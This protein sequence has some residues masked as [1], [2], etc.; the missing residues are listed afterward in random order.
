MRV[1]CEGQS[2]QCRCWPCEYSFK[3]WG[4]L[5][6]KTVSAQDYKFMTSG[7]GPVYDQLKIHEN[8]RKEMVWKIS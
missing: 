4:Y 3:V 1:R 6:D 5:L 2:I 8:F 7:V